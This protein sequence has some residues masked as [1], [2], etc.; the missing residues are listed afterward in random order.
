MEI[1]GIRQSDPR[2]SINGKINGVLLSPVV[3]GIP[4]D[5]K[6]LFDFDPTRGC[7]RGYQLETI[8]RL[9]CEPVH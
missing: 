7:G 5:I 9:T 8:G 1:E 3:L 4:A 2:L 6:R